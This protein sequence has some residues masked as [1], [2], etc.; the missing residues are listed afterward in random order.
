MK[1][2]PEVISIDENE[3]MCLYASTDLDMVHYYHEDYVISLKDRI[4]KL[5]KN[6]RIKSRDTE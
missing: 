3:T 6:L 5:E 2:F 1:S 4:R